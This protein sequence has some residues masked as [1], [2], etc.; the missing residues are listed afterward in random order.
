MAVDRML[1]SDAIYRDGFYQVHKLHWYWTLPI[2]SDI[3][4]A[5]QVPKEFCIQKLDTFAR[6]TSCKLFSKM[7][8]Q[9]ATYR[10]KH[11][12]LS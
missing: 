12:V 10:P 3:P 9:P 2:N 6:L 11:A 7:S 5:I 4:C 1:V 8:R